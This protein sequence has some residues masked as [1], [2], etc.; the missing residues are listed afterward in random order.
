MAFGPPYRK[1]NAVSILS[2]GPQPGVEGA[3]IVSA[4]RIAFDCTPPP[5]PLGGSIP[6]RTL[7]FGP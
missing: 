3:T 6:L 5:E 2:G 4:A 7:T 1:E